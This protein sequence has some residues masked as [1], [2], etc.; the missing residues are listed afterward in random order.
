MK[1]LEG[2]EGDKVYNISVVGYEWTEEDEKVLKSKP[3]PVILVNLSIFIFYVIDW[4]NIREE[5][6][7]MLKDFLEMLEEKVNSPFLKHVF[8]LGDDVIEVFE[9][10]DGKPKIAVTREL[11][12]LLLP[13]KLILSSP[14]RV[15]DAIVEETLKER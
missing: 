5:K 15:L 3:V 4:E 14:S 10:E 1:R 12:T 2:R 13:E 8:R 9:G 11:E 6:R 7:N